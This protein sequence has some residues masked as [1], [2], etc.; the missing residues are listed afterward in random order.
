MVKKGIVSG[1]IISRD[2]IEID[3]TKIDLILNL[4]PPTCVKDVRS[5]LGHA[6][7]YHHFIKD[8]SKI[9]KLLSNLRAKDMSFHFSKYLVASSKLEQALTSTHIF[10]PP[11]WGEPFE[12]MCGACDCAIRVILGQR[13]DKKPH[14]IYYASH[15]LNN[16]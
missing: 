7:F 2:G 4:P 5:F 16:V 8:F 10:H 11:I 14:V 15:T 12:M 3:K 9:A 13:I 6:G 1:H